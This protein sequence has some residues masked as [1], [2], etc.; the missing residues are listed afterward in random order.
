MTAAL[1]GLAISPMW[2]GYLLA[3]TAG[4]FTMGLLY[5]FTTVA[6]QAM[7]APEQAGAA[8]GITLTSLITLAG[9]GVVVSGTVFE[10]LQGAGMPPTGAISAILLALAAALGL[11]SAMVLALRRSPA[12][13]ILD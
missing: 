2:V 4:G 5:A 1:V 9:V 13:A 10:T 12:V 11:A 6:T 8:A 7:V 3:L